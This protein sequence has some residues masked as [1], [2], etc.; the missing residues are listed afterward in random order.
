MIGKRQTEAHLIAEF[1]T[2]EVDFISYNVKEDSVFQS[3][4]ETTGGSRRLCGLAVFNYMEPQNISP[5]GMDSI[6][7]LYKRNWIWEAVH[8]ETWTLG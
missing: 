8:L 1:T 7:G 6:E 3:L 2:S 4:W 5:G